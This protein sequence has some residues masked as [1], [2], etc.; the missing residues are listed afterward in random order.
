LKAARPLANLTVI[1]LVIASLLVVVSM[2]QPLAARLRLPSAVLVAAVGVAIGAVSSFLWYTSLTDALDE[3]AAPL[4]F[5]PVNSAH[6]LYG[7]LPILLFQAAI[8]IDVRRMMEDTAPL[9]LLAVVAVFVATGLIG[10]S[11]WALAGMPLVVCLLLGAIVA[12]TDPS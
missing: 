8:T 1:L 4:V 11:L 7:F 3:L 5:L 2:I 12:T 10:V 9:L 6:F